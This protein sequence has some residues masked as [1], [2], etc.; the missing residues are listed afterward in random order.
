[1]QIAWY[2]WLG[3]VLDS[4]HCVER[5]SWNLTQEFSRSKPQWNMKS[6]HPWNL[7]V[8]THPSSNRLGTRRHADAVVCIS[9]HFRKR[10]DFGAGAT[11]AGGVSA[12]PGRSIRSCSPAGASNGDLAGKAAALP[13]T[14]TVPTTTTTSAATAP[15]WITTTTTTVITITATATT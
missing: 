6:L 9:L 15:S 12:T 1:M 11:S 3:A 2:L 8:H 7:H 14:T 10:S 4:G 5:H 13:S